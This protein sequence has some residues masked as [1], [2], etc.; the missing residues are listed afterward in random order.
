MSSVNSFDS[1]SSQDTPTSQRNL[2]MRYGTPAP[3]NPSKN[4]CSGIDTTK[5]SLEL[6]RSAQETIF[7][8]Q[9]RSGV[10]SAWSLPI[11]TFPKSIYIMAACLASGSD[12]KL[13]AVRLNIPIPNLGRYPSLNALLRECN[14][15]GRQAFDC[16]GKQMSELHRVTFFAQERVL[17]LLELLAIPGHSP[18]SI[19]REIIHLQVI[20]EECTKLMDQIVTGFASWCDLID[21]LPK[22]LA[23]YVG[24]ESTYSQQEQE[25]K[26]AKDELDRAKR[27]LDKAHDAQDA[28]DMKLLELITAQVSQGLSKE[29]IMDHL[30]KAFDAEGSIMFGER[31]G[32]VTPH[33]HL[34]LIEDP[35]PNLNT[36]QLLKQSTAQ[37]SNLK[38][39]VED[40]AIWFHEISS[41]VQSTVRDYFNAM[42]DILPE[43]PDSALLRNIF[44]IQ[45]QLSAISEISKIYRVVWHNYIRPGLNQMETLDR[46]DVAVYTRESQALTSWCET[47]NTKIQRLADQGTKDIDVSIDASIRAIGNG[48]KEESCWFMMYWWFE[49]HMGDSFAVQS[50]W[51]VVV[52]MCIMSDI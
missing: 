48:A 13:R 26:Q 21:K 18:A 46:S 25:L 14:S 37:L 23:D 45:G 7:A 29:E 52:S 32:M 10:P 9:R 47:A 1:W 12:E 15:R 50:S 5:L 51:P 4:R 19:Q 41:L 40:L 16:S 36:L 44:H 11:Q 20:S 43:D 35:N 31:F 8:I 6:Q 38:V 33:A 17:R 3:E 49:H 2:S 24:P 34:E 27:R 30:S 22:H 39:Q 42:K 28:V